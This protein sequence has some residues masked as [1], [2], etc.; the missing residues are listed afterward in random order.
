VD[1][2]PDIALIGRARVGKDT[3]AAF[4]ADQYGYTPMAFADPLR[5]IAADLDPLV[6]PDEHGMRYTDALRA[7]GYDA[8]KAR[9]PEVRQ[10][11]QRLGVAV[12]DHV[13]PDVWVDALDRRV[14]A[15]PA[16]TPVVVTDVRFPNEAER[17][18]A[19]GFTLVRL[20]REA[21][22]GAAPLHVSETALDEWPT[23]FRFSN[24][25]PVDA[26]HGFLQFLVRDSA[27]Q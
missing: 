1:K 20:T 12:R 26:L 19:L 11:L 25:G 13:G 2:F 3:A 27:A 22:A 15:L 24:D 4:L 6:D 23:D 7:V 9:F 18:A 17:L 10:V 16:E 5:D 21:A 14:D 8:A